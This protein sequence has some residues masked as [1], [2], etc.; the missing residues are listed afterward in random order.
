MNVKHLH[1]IIITSIAFGEKADIV[2][3]VQLKMG[4]L[5][6]Y[7]VAVIKQFLKRVLNLIYFT[8]R[9][10][11]YMQACCK[12]PL[13]VPMVDISSRLQH[14]F[15]PSLGSLVSSSTQRSR[16]LLSADNI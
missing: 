6:P 4:A 5:H 16:L 3:M 8:I 7:F 14:S 13:T 11:K 1:I 2:L 12:L 9:L 15:S 10:S